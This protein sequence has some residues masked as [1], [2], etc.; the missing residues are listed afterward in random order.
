MQFIDIANI[1]IAPDRQRQAFDLASLQELVNSIQ[2]IGLLHPLV[3][4]ST[5]SGEC[6]LV[7]G[8]RRLR[9]IQEIYA[10]QG[11]FRCNNSS[12]PNNQVPYLMLGELSSLEAEEVELEEN[13]R[14]Q[15]LTWQELA[16]AHKRLHM[17]RTAQAA[18]TGTP[19]SIADTALELSGRSDGAYQDNIRKEIIIANHLD[20]PAI[21]KARN[22]QDAFKILKKQEIASENIKFAEQ[23]GS[24]YSASSHQLLNM[25]C[26]DW[27]QDVYEM[28]DVILTDP[29]YGIGADKFNDG[30]G[31]IQATA[32]LYEDSYENW[33]ALIRAW[34][35]LSF[36]VAKPS[37]HC[38][39]F[40]DIDHFLELK[41]EMQLAGW[42]VFRTPFIVVKNNS[43]RVPLPDR[44][45][46]RQYELLLYGIKGARPVTH[47]YSDVIVGNADSQLCHG[48]QKPVSVYQ[49][50]LQRTV[51]PGDT[52]LDCFAGT[53][54]IF[55]AAA[56]FN[57]T[58][59]GIEMS[60]ES[61]A[62]ALKRLQGLGELEA[63]LDGL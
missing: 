56:H 35:P 37:S 17:L 42:Y 53:G 46:R 26:L 39:V 1:K 15:D 63:Q 6:F 59:I 21:A 27:M 49:N 57:C 55:P 28:F 5:A 14:R 43:G 3:L 18:L 40:C 16:A 8:E 29:P 30:G 20:N 23:V 2:D 19:H 51:R 44:G 34:A 24:T 41:L 25:N 45:P 47:I 60:S 22:V 58:A 12:V 33:Q 38:Y 11:S 52:V 32:H 54:P 48:A 10:L 62:I 36:Q 4:R 13:L 61:Y 7:A 9:A 31:E 50:L